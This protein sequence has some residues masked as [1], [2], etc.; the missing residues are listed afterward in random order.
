M[1]DL[2]PYTFTNGTVADGDEV[3]E[4]FECTPPIGSIIAWL[5]TF[6][7]VTNGTTT[8]TS[9]GN[10]VNTGDT[11]VTDGV[12]VNMVVLNTTDSTST[13][14]TNVTSETSLAVNDDI[15]TSGQNYTIYSTP[16]LFDHWVE[17]NGQTLSDAESIFNGDTI[18][19]LNGVSGTKRF[20]RGSSTSGTTGGS[21]THQHTI[22][23]TGVQAPGATTASNNSIT[24]ATSTLPSYYEVVFIMRVK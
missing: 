11:F 20:L 19:N 12:E 1:V 5:K 21:E 3:N 7:A 10:L 17:C 2:I 14:I 22:S 16:R 9:A 24:G 23:T 8:S 4:N 15:F 6:T 18:P 13:Y